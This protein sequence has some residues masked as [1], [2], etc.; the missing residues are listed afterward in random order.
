MSMTTRY[1]SL[2]D[3]GVSQAREKE[4][5]KTKLL[6]TKKT[7]KQKKRNKYVIPSIKKTTDTYLY[8]YI[9]LCTDIPWIQY[10]LLYTCHIICQ[11]KYIL[12]STVRKRYNQ[13]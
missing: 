12:G 8:I 11:P 3:F 9:G 13:R 5:T 1:I 7:N 2:H 4:I 6:W 10:I